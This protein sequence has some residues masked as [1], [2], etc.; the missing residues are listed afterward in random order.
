MLKFASMAPQNTVQSQ[1]LKDRLN[2]LRLAAEKLKAE[3]DVVTRYDSRFAVVMA[4]LGRRE[5][6]EARA[7]ARQAA[8]EARRAA[9]AARAVNRETED[10]TAA[11]SPMT[12]APAATQQAELEKLEV[13]EDDTCPDCGIG[14]GEY[15]KPWCDAHEC[16]DCGRLFLTSYCDCGA[17]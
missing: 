2:A 17:F 4:R 3:C 8:R 7:A 11:N 9:Y 14:I 10:A 13:V 1:E 15:H 16:P 6:H 5:A 12:A